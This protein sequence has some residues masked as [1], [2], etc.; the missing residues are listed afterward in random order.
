[1]DE[2]TAGLDARSEQQVIDAIRSLRDLGTTIVIAS[3]HQALKAVADRRL[4][5]ADGRLADE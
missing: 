1:M 4:T 5:L 3:H 2:P